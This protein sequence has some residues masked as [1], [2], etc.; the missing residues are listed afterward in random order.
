MRLK[1]LERMGM[2]VAVEY[3]WETKYMKIMHNNIN[4]GKAEQKA[5]DCKEGDRFL[6]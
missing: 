1:E 5:R 6:Q 2:I 3:G 4:K